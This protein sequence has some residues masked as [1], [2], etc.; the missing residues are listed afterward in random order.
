MKSI[1][2]LTGVLIA[3]F[4][5]HD[6][7][8]IQKMNRDHVPTVPPGFELLGSTDINYNQGMV[9]YIPD[10]SGKLARPSD[11]QILTVQGHPEFTKRIVAM[12][13][14][15]RAERGILTPECAQD[16]IKRNEL[17]NEAPEVVGRAVW[18][19]IGAI[20]PENQNTS[21]DA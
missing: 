14:G 4:E 6:F 10:E 17:S 12:L 16:A 7:Q 1:P 2:E 11:I 18:K 9:K 8:N 5:T 13:V 21:H 20:R 15:I 3:L 19:V